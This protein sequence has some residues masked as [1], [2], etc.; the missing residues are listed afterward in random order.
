MPRFRTVAVAG[1][2]VSAVLLTSSAAY[3]GDHDFRRHTHFGSGGFGGASE[4]SSSM[5]WGFY[6]GPL[7]DLSPSTNDPFDGAKAT[8]TMMGVGGSTFFRVQIRGIDDSAIGKVYGAHLARRTMCRRQ[9][10]MRLVGSLQHDSG[11]SNSHCVRG[12][13]SD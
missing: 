10:G 9:W 12:Q 4:F 11:L 7:T 1:L 6:N 2:A 3:A 13:R 8:A 5:S